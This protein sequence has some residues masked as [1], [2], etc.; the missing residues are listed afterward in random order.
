MN[1]EV[2]NSILVVDDDLAA[3]KLYR[4]ILGDYRNILFAES[5]TRALE[6]IGA[7]E[8]I[9]L[10]LVDFNLPGATGAEVIRELKKKFPESEAILVTVVDDIQ[11][12]VESIK[13]GADNYLTDRK[14]VV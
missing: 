3:I 10:A 14:S 2:K 8:G 5:D 12:V 1:P 7:A 4:R 13:A 9:S 11:N 6:L